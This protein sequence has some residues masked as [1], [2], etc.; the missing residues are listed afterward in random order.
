MNQY[1]FNPNLKGDKTSNVLSLLATIEFVVGIILAILILLFSFIIGALMIIEGESEGF[2][3]IFFTGIIG[4]VSVFIT[5]FII[6]TL[7]KGFA[8]IVLHTYI[9]A[10]NSERIADNIKRPPLT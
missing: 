1:L 8:S 4:G 10:L 5:S 9:S 6:S 3:L 2:L 7:L